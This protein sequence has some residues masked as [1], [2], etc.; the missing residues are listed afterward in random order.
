LKNR[1]KEAALLRIERLELQDFGPFKDRQVIEFPAEPGVVI[2]Y[3]ENMRGKTSVLN[4]IRFALFGKVL[5]RGRR[6]GSL[7]QLGNWEKA[8]QGHYGFE[9]ALQ[10]SADDHDYRLARTSKPRPNIVPTRDDDYIHEWFLQRDGDVLGPDQARAEAERIMPEQISRFFLFDGELLQEYEDLLRD[11]S[12]MGRQI[13]EAIER[14]LGV[15]ILTNSRATLARLRD[16]YDKRE[17]KAAQA[18]QMTRE[19]G[20]DLEGLGETR[21][22]LQ[23]GLR[24]MREDVE[25][26]R[27][28]KA[29]LEEELRR[30]ERFAAVLDKRDGLRKAIEEL[31]EKILE[32]ATAISAAMSDAWRPLVAARAREAAESLRAEEREL[33]TYRMRHEVL[34]SLRAHEGSDCPACLQP[35][36][37]QAVARLEALAAAQEVEIHEVND[38]L[39]DVQRRLAVLEATARTG[40]ASVLH[41]LWKDLHGF[42]LDR[43]T[44]VDAAEELDRKLLEVDETALRKTQSEHERTVRALA[45]TEEGI[46]AQ[47]EKL[48]ENERNIEKVRT[49]LESMGGADLAG[50]RGQRALCMDLHALF[51]TAVGTYR[52]RLRTRVEADASALFLKLTTELDYVGL[53]INEHYGLTIVHQDGSDIPVRSAGAEHVVALSLVGALQKNAPLQGPIFIDSPFGRLDSQHTRNVVMALPTMTEQVC[54]LV[55]EDELHPSLARDLLKGQLRREYKLERITARH[56]RLERITGT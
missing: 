45:L 55:Y 2:V 24:E 21:R 50:L 30:G 38:R 9:V 7:H 29:S 44:K 39:R 20:V 28:D 4:A 15:P 49:R 12:D 5:G 27:L 8:A 47:Q 31:D 41:L 25:R 48:E 1:F 3:G 43:Y 46:R 10:F 6:E 13:S 34:A 18:D 52:D 22:V 11:E 56:T 35:V 54:L 16:D 23:D 14:I 40:D 51:S 19:L 26:L 37:K 42:E 36:S 32:K 53:R 17:A 33:Q